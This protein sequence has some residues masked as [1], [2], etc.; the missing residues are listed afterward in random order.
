MSSGSRDG[1]GGANGRLPLD[2]PPNYVYDTCMSSISIRDVSEHVYAILKAEAARR[3]ISLARYVRL[4]LAQK[5]R[6][7]DREEKARQEGK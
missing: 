4:V 6:E 1:P 7:L 2:P 3:E 5:A